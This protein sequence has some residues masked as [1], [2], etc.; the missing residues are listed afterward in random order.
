MDYNLEELEERM[1]EGDMMCFEGRGAQN[2]SSTVNCQ[3]FA[4]AY[5]TLKV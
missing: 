4:G 3:A 2:L 1:N 5:I